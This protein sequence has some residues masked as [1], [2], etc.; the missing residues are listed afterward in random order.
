MES[1]AGKKI[2]LSLQKGNL[3]RFSYHMGINGKI[4]THSDER[5]LSEVG[6]ITHENAVCLLDV[7]HNPYHPQC[8]SLKLLLDSGKI[9]WLV[10]HETNIED[11]GIEEVK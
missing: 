5:C 8:V 2:L 6:K 9:A 11:L 1:Q 10:V 7:K 4:A 3:F